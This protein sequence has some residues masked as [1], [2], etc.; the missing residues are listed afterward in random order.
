VQSSSPTLATVPDVGAQALPGLVWAFRFEEDGTAEELTAGEPI[1][2]DRGWLWLHCN[3]ADARAC[4]YLKADLA[5]PAPAAELL[6]SQ[7]PHQQVHGRGSC[8]YGTIS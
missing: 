8:I 6:T 4:R 5:L 2:E 1:E 7:D 3:L